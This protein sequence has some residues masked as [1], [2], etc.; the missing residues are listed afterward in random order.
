MYGE[1]R[2]KLPFLNPSAGESSLLGTEGLEDRYRVFS[3]CCYRP[4]WLRQQVFSLENIIWGVATRKSGSCH[5]FSAL[6]PVDVAQRREERMAWVEEKGLGSRF[7][8]ECSAAAVPIMGH[9]WLLIG[10]RP[11]PL[12]SQPGK[13]LKRRPI[14]LR[15]FLKAVEPVR[16]PPPSLVMICL[17]RG[18]FSGMSGSERTGKLLEYSSPALT[19]ELRSSSRSSQPLVRRTGKASHFRSF[20]D[21]THGYGSQFE[22]SYVGVEPATL[23]AFWDLL[24]KNIPQTCRCLDTEVLFVPVT[25][26]VSAAGGSFHFPLDPRISYSTAAVTNLVLMGLTGK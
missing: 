15:T 4:P 22:I 18:D 23:N 16:T 11:L 2:A 3:S 10:A 13:S 25:G 19:P 1:L 24:A 26:C 6:V 14:E 7:W 9:V 5:V 21:V 8:I 12:R 17:K 20:A